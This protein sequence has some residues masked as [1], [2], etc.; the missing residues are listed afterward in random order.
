MPESTSTPTGQGRDAVRA[1]RQ[2][3]LQQ[4]QTQAT[5][6]GYTTTASTVGQDLTKE[7]LVKKSDEFSESP[8][9]TVVIRRGTETVPE[10]EPAP[11]EMQV[12][13]T[14]I[15]A[16]SQSQETTKILKTYQ[17]SS[18]QVT[19]GDCSV[20]TGQE[21]AQPDPVTYEVKDAETAKKDEL[22]TADVSRRVVD[23]VERVSER[24]VD[25]TIEKIKFV[26][27][28]KQVERIIVESVEMKVECPE[29]KQKGEPM[30]LEQIEEVEGDL[31]VVERIIEEEVDWIM[32]EP[33]V[34][35]VPVTVPREIEVINM[36]PKF[37][38]VETTIERLVQKPVERLVERTVNVPVIVIEEEVEWEEVELIEEVPKVVEVPMQVPIKIEKPRYVT[39][40]LVVEVPKVDIREQEEKR[41]KIIYEE[42]I[43]ERAIECADSVVVEKEVEVAKILE[44]EK[45]V[46]VPQIEYVDKK[47]ERPLYRFVRTEMPIA[48]PEC[49]IVKKQVKIPKI[50]YVDKIVQVPQKKKKT[51]PTEVE[52]RTQEK[53]THRIY[54]QPND[55]SIIKYIESFVDKPKVTT[56]EVNVPV[57]KITV[58]DKEEL[59]PIDVEVIKYVEVPQK[60]TV[61]VK[62]QR[63]KTIYQERIFEVPKFQFVDEIIYK[64]IKQEVLVIQHRPEEQEVTRIREYPEHQEVPK[65]VLGGVKPAPVGVLAPPMTAAVQHSNQ[66]VVLQ[67][68]EQ[69]RIRPSSVSGVLSSKAL[70]DQKPDVKATVGASAATKAALDGQSG[71]IRLSAPIAPEKTKV[72]EASQGLAEV[73]ETQE[74]PREVQRRVR[75]QPM[76]RNP[77]SVRGER[78]ILSSTHSV[79]H[80]TWHHDLW[81]QLAATLNDGNE[82]IRQANEQLK[83]GNEMMQTQAQSMQNTRKS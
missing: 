25:H 32:E 49:Q 22:T 58:M 45:I 28:I 19:I 83:L 41:A 78:S 47:V 65:P 26:P 3:E 56:V 33:E 8:G 80:T 40:E 43:Q 10:I 52:S 39:E 17:G 72:T 51:K 14:T 67:D 61:K 66:I 27:E 34:I 36:V 50:E 12:I 42:I 5:T 24:Q 77:T 74:V 53:E 48:A 21:K 75:G 11:A 73:S 9:P 55:A 76:Q 70:M 63:H 1:L 6:T 79:V 30:I 13:N 44:V 60:Q 20:R 71:L 46:P 29:I 68:Q 37:I 62:K 38:D 69:L 57:Q 64:K 81:N 35:H 54:G 18:H 23:H 15:V 7:R 2:A 82:H 59:V 16:Q 4:Q 31:I